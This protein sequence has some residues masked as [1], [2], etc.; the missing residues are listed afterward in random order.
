MEI[1]KKVRECTNGRTV[2]YGDRSKSNVVLGCRGEESIPRGVREEQVPLHEAGFA[3]KNTRN[4]FARKN[5]RN[6][7]TNT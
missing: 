6:T 4:I 1:T 5:I 3:R 2:G 7:K